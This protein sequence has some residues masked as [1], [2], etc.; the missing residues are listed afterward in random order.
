LFFNCAKENNLDWRA[1]L[2]L[3]LTIPEPK[4][5]HKMKRIL[6]VIS[7][8]VCV[9]AQ[10]QKFDNLALTP[11]MGWNSWNKF[12]GRVRLWLNEYVRGQN[13]FA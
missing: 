7:C 12:Q 11:Q 2:R 4:H 8:A 1:A 9:S 6:L 10:A 3:S 5:F 13:L